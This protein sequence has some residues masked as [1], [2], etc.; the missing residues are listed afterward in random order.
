[1]CIYMYVCKQ[2]VVG[3]NPT[4]AALVSLSVSKIWRGRGAKELYKSLGGGG[5]KSVSRGG[6]ERPNTALIIDDVI[7]IHGDVIIDDT[8]ICISEMSALM[9]S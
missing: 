3:L 7:C 5:G 8:C 6:G 9:M 1:M 4:W 2:Y